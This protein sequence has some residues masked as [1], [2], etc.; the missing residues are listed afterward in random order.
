[1]VAKVM[2]TTAVASPLFQSYRC[3]SE[4]PRRP[5][6]MSCSNVV[7]VD[8]TFDDDDDDDD[9][10]VNTDTSDTQEYGQ[11]P[12]GHHSSSAAT[13]TTRKPDIVQP[14]EAATSTSTTYYEPERPPPPPPLPSRMVV[15]LHSREMQLVNRIAQQLTGRPQQVFKAIVVECAKRHY[16]HG[17]DDDGHHHH[18]HHDPALYNHLPRAIWRHVREIMDP[19]D[20]LG[21]YYA[22]VRAE[23]NQMKH[24]ESSSSS[25]T[26]TKTPATHGPPP[27]PKATTVAAST[28]NRHHHPS[29]NNAAAAAS[30]VVDPEQT[31]PPASSATTPMP[32]HLVNKATNKDPPRREVHTQQQQSPPPPPPL[33]KKITKLPGSTTA[34]H[35]D[36][37]AVAAA[38]NYLQRLARQRAKY[39]NMTPVQKEAYH[40]RRRELYRAR[41]GLAPQF[42]L[43]AATAPAPAVVHHSAATAPPAPGQ[44]EQRHCSIQSPVVPTTTNPFYAPPGLQHNHFPINDRSSSAAP[45]P[46]DLA[47]P[48]TATTTL[49]RQAAVAAS[50]SAVPPV[51]SAAATDKRSIMQL[52]LRFGYALC[53]QEQQES[54]RHQLSATVDG[55]MAGLLAKADRQLQALTTAAERD[56]LWDDIAAFTATMDH[57]GVA[58]HAG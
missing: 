1:M 50:A 4:P 28:T 48:T 44:H 25:T 3:R 18:H 37:A 56:Q 17:D 41:R 21:V 16:D 11:L 40:A 31:K 35:D 32:Q 54:G 22:A 53:W 52:A 34:V 12:G 33:S 15:G 6:K 19:T 57:G 38:V 36:A 27:P 7:V 23:K 29:A 47:F 42:G 24:D 45:F 26:T 55:G 9:D 13:T 58:D 10:D 8:L 46:P 43:I 39:A 14:Y 5:F 49:Q 30:V 51:T 20:Y 2:T